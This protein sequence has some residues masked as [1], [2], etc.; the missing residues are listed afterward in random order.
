[1]RVLMTN[2]EALEKYGIV[3]DESLLTAC[4]EVVFSIIFFYALFRALY[5]WFAG[6]GIQ[7]PSWVGKC[8]LIKEVLPGGDCLG[9]EKTEPV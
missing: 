8:L 9:A 5:Q 3:L 2:A 7:F 1:M 4:L 6:N